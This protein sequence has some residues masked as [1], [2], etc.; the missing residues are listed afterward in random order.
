VSSKERLGDVLEK[1]LDRLD[2]IDDKLEA[3]SGL[4]A[5]VGDLKGIA[6]DLRA[7]LS[8]LHSRHIEQASRDGEIFN[9]H[10]RA[11]QELDGRLRKHELKAEAEAGAAAP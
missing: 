7:D 8:T 4:D 1:I 3:L 9:R 6:V 2:S 11:I 5:L 10:Q